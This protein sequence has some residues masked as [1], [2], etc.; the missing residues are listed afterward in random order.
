MEVGPTAAPAFWQCPRCKTPNPWASYLT[1]CVSCGERRPPAEARAS[2]VP[3]PDPPKPKPKPSFALAVATFGYAVVVLIS[4]ALIKQLGDRWWPATLLM[5]SPRWP[6]LLPIPLLIAWAAARRRFWPWAVHAATL[7]VVAGP[8]MGLRLPIATLFAASPIST[9][10]RVRVVSFDRG[11]GGFDPSALVRFV[12]DERADVL[13]LQNAQHDPVLDG[14]FRQIGWHSDGEGTIWSRFPIVQDLGPSVDEFEVR[15]DRAAKLHRARIR[16]KNGREVVVA[17]VLMPAMDDAFSGLARRDFERIRLF[18][19][20]RRRQA[21]K[22]RDALRATAATPLILAGDFN[23]PPDSPT[24][25]LLREAYAS[26]FERVGWGYGYTRP[27]PLPWI[28][29]DRILASR[30]CRFTSCR[31]GPRIGPAHRPIVAEVIVGPVRR[32]GD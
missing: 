30:E 5:F 8:L 14:Y 17:N 16:L 20:W 7:A 27:G 9:G 11:G 22:V 31:V 13:C 28:A 15:G 12:A 23:M 32:S 21:L 19:D 24:M 6:F 26:G 3:K 25:G 1:S 4:L 18:S 29:A 10:E 2:F